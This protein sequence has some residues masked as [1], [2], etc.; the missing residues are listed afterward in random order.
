MT[1]I[2]ELMCTL[3]ATVLL[4]AKVGAIPPHQNVVRTGP[5]EASLEVLASGSTGLVLRHTDGSTTQYPN[6]VVAT[7]LRTA[8]HSSSGRVTIVAETNG[9]M[10]VMVVAPASATTLAGGAAASAA[11]SDN[12]RF[13]LWDRPQP[14][15]APPQSSEY[16][17]VDVDALP[18]PTDPTGA[19]L[20]GEVVYP[21][22]GTDPHIR[23]SAITSVGDAT[24]AFLNLSHAATAVAIRATRGEAPSVVTR[25][26]TATDLADPAEIDGAALPAT[27]AAGPTISRVPGDGLV[28]RLD[29]AAAAQGHS[30][31]SARL[32]IW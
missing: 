21:T 5:Y 10:Y 9:G 8:A 2:R 14:P 20:G 23:A 6:D 30:G 15:G 25:P 19:P 3:A 32:R 26:L 29:F 12:G 27:L 4:A 31:K 11:V 18:L 7:S 13:I 1:R 17:L 28:V 24:F 16:R 22:A